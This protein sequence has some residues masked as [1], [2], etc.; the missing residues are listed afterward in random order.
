MLT[1][2]PS[3]FTHVLASPFFPLLLN[4]SNWIP[5]VIQDPPDNE[6]RKAEQNALSKVFISAHTVGLLPPYIRGIMPP[7]EAG[8]NRTPIFSRLYDTTE[9]CPS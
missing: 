3:S 6:M 5:S 4:F 2:L 1:S 7:I 8:Q 9:F